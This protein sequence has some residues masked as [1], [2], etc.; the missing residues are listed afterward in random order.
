MFNSGNGKYNN[1]I[2]IEVVSGTLARNF[3]NS[4]FLYFDLNTWFADA[5]FN[6]TPIYKEKEIII[7]QLM[8][9]G[10][11]QAIAEVIY[12]VDFESGR[13]IDIQI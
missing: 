10:N 2:N 4:F 8:L 12:R 3:T 11:G 1:A 7:L 6:D 13:E 5:L 9:C